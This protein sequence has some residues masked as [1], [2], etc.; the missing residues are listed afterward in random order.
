MVNRYAHTFVLRSTALACLLCAGMPMVQGKE[1][2]CGSDTVKVGGGDVRLQP[3]VSQNAA[4]AFIRMGE[5][6]A[7]RDIALF[8]ADLLST[9]KVLE[10]DVRNLTRLFERCDR[11]WGATAYA[12][13]LQASSKRPV[14]EVVML[15]DLAGWD[16]QRTAVELGLVSP[17]SGEPTYTF[18][19]YLSRQ[20][21]VWKRV[22]TAPLRWRRTFLDK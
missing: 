10:N 18:G 3:P 15:Y 17:R 11:N 2:L 22:L 19:V 21:Q 7:E 6:V 16:W 20:Q 8:T 5:M 1:H 14:R 13:A 9:Y 12:L 4:Q